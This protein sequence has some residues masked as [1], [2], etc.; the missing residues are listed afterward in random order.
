MI[1]AAGQAILHAT[2]AALVIE[3]LLRLWRVD[4]PGERL[5]MRALAIAAPILL[6]T[7]YIAA[8]PWRSE[9]WFAERWA[10]FAGGSWNDISLGGVGVATAASLALSLAGTALYLRDA[11]PFLS[12]R[13]VPPAP[14]GA[15]PDSHPAGQRVRRAL[16]SMPPG[17]TGHPSTVTVL[18]LDAPVLLCRGIDSTAIVV[19]TGALDRLDDEALGAALA[20]EAAHL[21]ARDPLVGWWL[22]AARTLQFFNPVVQVVARQAVQDIERRADLA[23]EALGQGV[24]LASAVHRLSTAADVQ[25]DL[26]LPSEGGHLADGILASA[27]RRA[28]DARCQLLLEGSHPASQPHRAGRLALTGAAVAALLFLVV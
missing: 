15:L 24:P 14:G 4:D 23:V 21:A 25:S 2:V 28:I 5:A 7:T 16:A 10:L 9:P 12:D 19:S 27:H 17:V 18:D 26:A 20:H 6:T 8:A 3:A 11:V 22:M 13:L 1:A